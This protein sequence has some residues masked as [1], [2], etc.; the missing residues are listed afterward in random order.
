MS[1]SEFER[2]VNLR[3]WSNAVVNQPREEGRDRRVVAGAIGLY[4]RCTPHTL[5]LLRPRRE[6]PRRRASLRIFVVRCGL[7]CDP[8]VG[9]SFTQWRHDTTLPPRGLGLRAMGKSSEC[10]RMT[11][12]VKSGKAQNERMFFR[13][14]PESGHRAMA[15]HRKTVIEAVTYL[16]TSSAERTSTRPLSARRRHFAKPLY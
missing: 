13:F 6:R 8:P 9:G 12:G 1:T 16:R 2:L 5:A 4:Q 15:K 7:P 11:T 3:A 14:A 10:L